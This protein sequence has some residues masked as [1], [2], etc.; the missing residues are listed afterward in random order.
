MMSNQTLETKMDEMKF[1]RVTKEQI[2]AR[3]AKVD[4]F[5]LPATTTTICNMTLDNG[6]SVRGESACV[7]K[8]NFNM[9]IG[10]KLAHDDAFRKMWALFGFMLAENIHNAKL[11]AAGNPAPR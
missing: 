1:P 11:R 2:D 3:I 10:E 6:Y 5:V 8:R 9:A 7:D 4:F